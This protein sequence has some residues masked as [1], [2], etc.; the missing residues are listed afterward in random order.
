MKLEPRARAIIALAGFPLGKT[1]GL[2][3]APPPAAC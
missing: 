1:G 2:I 3:E